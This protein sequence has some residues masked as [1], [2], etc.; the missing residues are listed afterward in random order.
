MVAMQDFPGRIGEND[1]SLIPGPSLTMLFYVSIMRHTTPLVLIFTLAL[2]GCAHY[3]EPIG[4]ATAKLRVVSLPGNATEV[5][6]LNDTHCVG[7]SAGL[8]ASLG[9]SVKNGTNQGRSLHMP[10]QDGVPRLAA[11]EL[12]IRAGQPFAAQFKANAASGPKGAGWSY[13]ACSKSFAFTPKE[14]EYYEA[15]L[16]Q[17]NTGCQINVFRISRERDG[18]Y[19]RRIAEQSRELKTRCN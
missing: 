4:G 11:G 6:E 5:R 14:G 1:V 19:V 13:P 3:I 10:L 16:E 15:Q 12:N 17:L 18:S 8:I 2:A 9:L 7:S